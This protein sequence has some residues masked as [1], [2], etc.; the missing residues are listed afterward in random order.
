[1]RIGLKGIFLQMSLAVVFFAGV[2]C[3]R[4]VV[5]AEPQ[6]EPPAAVSDERGDI[7]MIDILDRPESFEG[8]V[9]VL[10]GVFRGWDIRCENST[11]QTRSDWVL[12]DWTGG[13][14]YVT[15]QIPAV[16]SPSNP[17]DELISVKGRVL[18]G[19]DGPYLVAVDVMVL[20]EPD[21]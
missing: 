2:S 12:E 18:M 4:A 6:E 13:C 16:L 15:G 20:P 21:R 14:L 8:A 19:E 1:M 11:R 10:E 9:V 7:G 17:K 5:N 3:T